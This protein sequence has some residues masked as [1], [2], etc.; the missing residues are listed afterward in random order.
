MGV[1]FYVINFFSLAVLKIFS[2]S[3]IL[4]SF[5]MYAVEDPFGLN[6]LGDL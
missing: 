5:I 6:L 3:L 2:L 4:D 1:S